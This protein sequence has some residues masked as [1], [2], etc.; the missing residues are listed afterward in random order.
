PANAP[1]E[2]GAAA[3]TSQLA[4]SSWPPGIPPMQQ[5]RPTVNRAPAALTGTAMALVIPKQP[6][7]PFSAN[8]ATVSAGAAQHSPQVAGTPT[9]IGGLTF[10]QHVSLC[11]ELAFHPAHL[12]ETL[13][14]YRV[15]AEGKAEMDRQWKE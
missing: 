11:A 1:P 5:P 4:P 12:A 8:T 10:E 7:L 9:G 14:R 15:T 13:A 2:T 6:P 3:D